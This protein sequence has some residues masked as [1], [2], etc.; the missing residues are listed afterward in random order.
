MRHSQAN[1]DRS[2]NPLVSAKG[3][4]LRVNSWANHGGHST[5]SSAN[6]L[7]KILNDMSD[8][9]EN[10]RRT[11]AFDY[12]TSP[13][14]SMFKRRK[15]PVVGKHRNRQKENQ[16]KYRSD[17]NGNLSETTVDRPGYEDN[18][19]G[20]VESAYSKARSN[21]NQSE[22]HQK[23]I[24]TAKKLLVQKLGMLTDDAR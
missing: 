23:S 1:L 4:V 5:N 13:K 16:N 14:P 19:A 6:N 18:E 3:E 10:N 24:N 21:E 2:E 7:K 11:S 17:P 20:K 8:Q 22:V 9:D 12:G 15:T